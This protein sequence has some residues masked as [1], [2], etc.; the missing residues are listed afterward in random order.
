MRELFH[1]ALCSIFKI[2]SHTL[3][4]EN[5]SATT[6]L[7]SDQ[8]LTTVQFIHTILA[9]FLPITKPGVQNTSSTRTTKIIFFTCGFVLNCD[10]IKNVM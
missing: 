5:V 4:F 3:C 7:K 8:M 6:E 1:T 9:V 2:H 10:K